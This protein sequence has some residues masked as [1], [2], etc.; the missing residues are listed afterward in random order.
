VRA[1]EGVVNIRENISLTIAQRYYGR[2]DECRTAPRAAA[3]AEPS[4]GTSPAPARPEPAR[5]PSGGRVR[6]P[7]EL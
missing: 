7:S 4:A 5:E 6:P 1:D 3:R 2:L